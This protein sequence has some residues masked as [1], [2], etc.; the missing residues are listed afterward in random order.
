MDKAQC[1]GLMEQSMR[2][3]GAMDGLM[4]KEYSHILKVR[5]MMVIGLMIKPMVLGNI[6][7]RTEL[8]TKVIGLEIYNKEKV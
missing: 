8:H 4:V 1:S 7:I 6:H 5:F 2:V 3:I